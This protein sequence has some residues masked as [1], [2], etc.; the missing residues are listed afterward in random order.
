MITVY[1]NDV[2]VALAE[3]IAEQRYKR[4]KSAHVKEQRHDTTNRKGKDLNRVGVYGEIAFAKHFNLYP[5][6]DTTPRAA[7]HDADFML[8]ECVIDVKTSWHKKPQLLVPLTKANAPTHMYVQCVAEI[9]KRRVYIVGWLWSHDARKTQK[10]DAAG[11][12]RWATD[13]E[14]LNHNVEDIPEYAADVYDYV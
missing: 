3:K 12:M 11:R 10:Q 5:Q 2:D 9:E 13:F 8:G 6:T 1:L 7:I 14:N 4:N